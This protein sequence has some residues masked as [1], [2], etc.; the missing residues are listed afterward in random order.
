MNRGSGVIGR[1]T[2]PCRVIAPSHCQ[3]AM[4]RGSGA[5]GRKTVPCRLIA[6]MFLFLYSDISLY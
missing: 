1:K 2:V 3:H 4:N 6:E 5:I